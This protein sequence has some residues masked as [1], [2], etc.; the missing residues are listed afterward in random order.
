MRIHTDIG[1]RQIIHSIAFI[2]VYF[3]LYGTLSLTAGMKPMLGKRLFQT[4]SKIVVTYAGMALI[5]VSHSS[6]FDPSGKREIKNGDINKETERKKKIQETLSRIAS[7]FAYPDN[8]DA[9]INEALR[10][11]GQ[12]CKASRSYLFLFHEK[13]ATMDNTHEWCAVGVKP[14]KERLQ[15]LSINM[16]PWWYSSL[17][18]GEMIHIKDLASLPA[19][20]SAEKN[21]MEE[22]DIKSVLSL[23]VF[24]DG[25]LKGFIGIDNVSETGEWKPE[26]IDSLFTL[27]TLMTMALKNNRM[28]TQI[29]QRANHLKKILDLSPVPILIAS[30][31]G[32]IKSL[33]R[34]FTDTFKYEHTDI[35]DLEHFFR[36]TIPDT[37]LRKIAFSACKTKMEDT[38]PG[39]HPEE[40]E[41]L[42]KD[43][44]TRIVNINHTIVDRDSIFIFIDLTERKRSEEMLHLNESRLEALLDLNRKKDLSVKEIA[45]FA[46]EKGVQL[47]SSKV[48]YIAF[49]DRDR[50]TLT[51][52]SWSSEVGK[53]CKTAK[54]PRAFPLDNT[55]LWGEVIR[56]E[57]PI[58]LNDY[59]SP[60]SLKKGYPQGHI[61]LERTLNVPIFDG[62]KLV[63][64]AGVANK[65]S[66]YDQSDIHQLMLL[67][68][69]MWEIIE[70]IKADEKLRNYAEEL[71]KLNV[72][73]QQLNS[74]MKYVEEIKRNFLANVSH[75][76]RTPLMPIV[77]YSGLLSEEYFGELNNKQKE[78]LSIVIKNGEHLRRLIDSLLYLSSLQTKEFNYERDFLQLTDVINKAIS[79]TSVEN[80]DSQKKIAFEPAGPLPLIYADK[81]YISELFIHLLNNAYKFTNNGGAISITAE[82]DNRYVR[83][84][85]ADDGV[86]ISEEKLEKIFDVFY[87]GDGSKTRKFSG[88]GIGLHMCKKICEDHGG[89]IRIESKENSGTTVRLRFPIYTEE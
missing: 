66:D 26:D 65:E 10:E 89:D 81:D 83:I 8:I 75:E 67:M 9:A 88:T 84:S 14:Q 30:E 87:Q 59:G 64:V 53:M 32:T 3:L 12:L 11:I 82:S 54:R 35:P 37:R 41:I 34:R 58:V 27:S 62:K 78:I 55:G 43:G 70:H 72:E 7:I 85:I 21:I 69:G 31:D 60:S 57:K 47:T 42:C 46:L 77:G 4:L 22:Q 48:G 2:Q 13:Q 36:L 38:L 39:T 56:Q 40:W 29:E 71:T 28:Q 76:L 74:E 51:I 25:E 19:E 86:G 16:F 49:L 5:S 80:S 73:L 23:P 45:D 52:D 15:N 68:E 33:N 6:S 44:S 1:Y 17:K 50:S 79:I 20:A 18:K 24:I 61:K 63:G